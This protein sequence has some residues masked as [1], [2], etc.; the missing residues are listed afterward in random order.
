MQNFHKFL[1]GKETRSGQNGVHYT[2]VSLE[3]RYV[4]LR[5]NLKIKCIFLCYT[6]EVPVLNGIIIKMLDFFQIVL[7]LKKKPNK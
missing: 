1:E 3:F 6:V 4:N 2:I 5:N 7:R